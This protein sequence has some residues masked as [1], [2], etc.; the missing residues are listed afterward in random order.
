MMTGDIQEKDH[1]IHGS[2][3]E[4]LVAVEEFQQEAERSHIHPCIGNRK[5]E[6]DVV[7]G[8]KSLEPAP[9]NILLLA[10]FHSQTTT[11]EQHFESRHYTDK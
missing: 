3:G 5:G 4:S 11:L 6:L 1:W 2:E 10:R 8:C 7:R 9:S